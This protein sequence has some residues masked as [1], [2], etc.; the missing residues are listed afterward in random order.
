MRAAH[1]VGRVGGLAV[2]LGVGAAMFSTGTGTA[3]ADR[4]GTDS[5]SNASAGGSSQSAAPTRARRGH[6]SPSPAASR[7]ARSSAAPAAAT[8]IAP[9]QRRAG[10][11]AADVPDAL[12]D[13]V[14]DPSPSGGGVPDTKPDVQVATNPVVDSPDP[15]VVAEPVAADPGD[16]QSFVTNTGGPADGAGN[17]SGG[18]VDSPLAAAFLAYANR[19]AH[20]SASSPQASVV[21]SAVTNNG[22]TVDPKVF[23]FANQAI[24]QGNLNASSARGNELTYTFVDSSNGGK[25]DIGNVPT[26]LDGL[27]PAGLKGGKQSFTLLPYRTWDNGPTAQPTGTQTWTVRVSEVT[28]F[29]KFLVNIPLVGMI[30]QPIIDFLQKAPLLSTLLAPIIGGSVQ[31]PISFD[32]GTLTAGAPLSYTAKVTSF[33]GVKISANFFPSINSSNLGPD[34]YGA[35]LFNGPGLGSPGATD[36]YGAY[37][38]AGSTPGLSVLRGALQA[39]SGFNVITWDPRGE[40]Q[41]GGV[42]QLDNPFYEGRDVSALIDWANANTPTVGGA[43]NTPMIGM[44][45]GSYGGG[46]QMTTVDPRVK[47]IVPAIAWNSLNESLYPDQVFK[48]AWANTLYL[49]LLTSGARVNSEI[50]KA[51]LSGNL[52]GRISETAQAVLSSSGPTAL[53]TKL[54]IP[55]MYVQGIVDALFPLAQAV[56]NAQTQLLQNPFFAGANANLVKMIWFCGGHGVCLDPVDQT[57]QAMTIFTQNMEWLNKYVKGAPLPIDA[58]VPTFQWWDQQGQLYQ[59][60]LMPFAPG[61]VTGSVAGSNSTGGRLAIL[62]L[63]I[64]GSGPNTTSCDVPDACAF[65]LNQTFATDARKSIDVNIATAPAGTQ[66]VGTPQV[67]FTYSGFGNAKAVYGQILD[68][69]TG[70]VLGNIVTPIP[71]TLDGKVHTVTLADLADIAYTAPAGGSNLTLQIVGGATLYKNGRFGSIN[72]SNATVT[73]P[74]TTQ[75]VTPG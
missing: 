75:G 9:I 31:A 36:V 2:A 18:Q 44:I 13:S 20:A 73:L 66:I 67:S 19:R 37:Q 28:K 64:G 55:T 46:I 21:A 16:M 71:V 14:S 39:G 38:A 61:F 41:S 17:G 72:I 8:V 69:S 40:G 65:P 26:S 1:C 27:L 3:L 50:P 7:S 25:I 23:Y 5:G 57:A 53:L 47:A 63:A 29:D 33:D 42:L 70:R 54:D 15:I 6:S 30:A 10:A 11:A 34:N 32:L 45:G 22:V 62:P 24:L 43:T 49:A 51:I 60:S 74:T 12:V 35:T 56:E 58:L 68:N 4:S 59:S 52:F 48:T